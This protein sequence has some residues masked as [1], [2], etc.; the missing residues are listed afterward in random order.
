M[1]WR[2]MMLPV[3]DEIGSA[4][5][6]RAVVASLDDTQCERRCYLARRAR[7]IDR[8]IGVG[9]RSEDRE[10][11]RSPGT[12]PDCGIEV[13]AEPLDDL[14][15]FGAGVGARALCRREVRAD[16]TLHFADA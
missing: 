14:R 2:S 10:S 13:G 11:G 6:Q 15:H 3:V 4:R 1:Y 12:L 5:Q 8:T 7:T 9:L 16:P